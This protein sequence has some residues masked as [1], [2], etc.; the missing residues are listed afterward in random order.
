MGAA[1]KVVKGDYLGCSVFSSFGTITFDQAFKIKLTLCKNIIVSYEVMDE[2]STKS[3]TSAVGRA[4]V[5]ALFLGPIGL[6][7]GVTAKSKGTY[8]IAIEF[9]DG[10]K[11]LIEVND[12]I[13][14]EFIK[15]MFWKQ[16]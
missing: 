4:A 8:L 1:N 13:H 2:K 6:L 7:A 14:K 3:A 15:L 11:S 9:K 16:Q 5:G 12:K 10:K